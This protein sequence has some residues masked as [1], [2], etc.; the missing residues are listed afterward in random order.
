MNVCVLAPR[1]FLCACCCAC[2]FFLFRPISRAAALVS[3]FL[4]ASVRVFV[5][6]YGQELAYAR[7]QTTFLVLGQVLLLLFPAG[8][9]I[10]S[11]LPSLLF[12]VNQFMF[13]CTTAVFS[14]KLHRLLS[15]FV[16]LPLRLRVSCFCLSSCL[17][18]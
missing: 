13:L 14:R 2:I 15:L 12:D 11:L 6:A 18:S 1:A 16:L 8:A 3:G 7:E 10:F 9:A 5:N 17:Y 4:R